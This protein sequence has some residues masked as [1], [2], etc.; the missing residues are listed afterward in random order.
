MWIFFLLLDHGHAS[1]FQPSILC[2]V[3]LLFISFLFYL[4]HLCFAF[5]FFISILGPV[6]WGREVISIWLGSR[7]RVM[8]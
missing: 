7:G 5:G 1:L 8:L 3:F 2:D 4:F 6:G